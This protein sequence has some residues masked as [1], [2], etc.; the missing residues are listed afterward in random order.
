[1]ICLMI[2]LQLK[3]T[4][5]ILSEYQLQIIEYNNAP[6]DKKKK[7]ITNLDN[8]KNTNSTIKVLFEFRVIIKTS[9]ENVRIQNAIFGK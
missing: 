1:M 9:F 7:A 3:V 6:L 8:K 2:V 5:E 4:E